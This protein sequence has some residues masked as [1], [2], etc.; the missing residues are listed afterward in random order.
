MVKRIFDVC[1]AGLAILVL[2]PVLIVVGLAIWGYDRG[3]VLFLQERGGRYGTTFKIYKFRSM[4]RNADQIGSY[5]TASNDARITRI[6]KFLR[7]TSLDELPQLFNVLKGD[8]SLV[9]P[10]PDVPAQK[11]LYSADEWLRRHR[12]RPGVTGL[13]QAT[14]R[15]RGT[16]DQRKSLDLFYVENQSF[17]F[18]LKIIGLTVLQLFKKSGN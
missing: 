10:R 6:G 13:A 5:Q 16:A 3:P 14:I 12:V 18:D 11:S 7:R 8:M 9:G 4:V 17:W 2:S 15:S 1:C